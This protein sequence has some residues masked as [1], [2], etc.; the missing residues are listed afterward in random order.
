[1]R[2]MDMGFPNKDTVD[3]IRKLYP[4][5]ARVEL[6][7]MADPFARLKPGDR[8]SV[9]FVD[10]TGTVFVDWDSG[11]K[12]GCV[13]GED[14]I[15]K[16]PTVTEKAAE[17]IRAVAGS[18]HTNMF[19]VAAVQRIAHELGYCELVILIED[20]REAYAQFILTGEPSPPTIATTYSFGK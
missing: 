18:G 2:R 9:G 3:R 19:D 14:R 7:S 16:L 13:Y 17:Q 15:R 20:N 5:G 11:S 6:V 1:M 10:D 4:A 12:L 8:G